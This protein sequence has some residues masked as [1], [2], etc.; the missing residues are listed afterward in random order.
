MLRQW[1]KNAFDF[2]ESLPGHT[3]PAIKGDCAAKNKAELIALAKAGAKRPIQR[4]VLGN[5]LWHYTNKSSSSYDPKFDK[6]IKSLRLDWFKSSA[7]KKK[8]E[9]IVLAKAGTKRP[10]TK[11]SSLGIALSNYTRNNRNTHDPEFDRLIRGLRP[12]WFENTADKNKQE[13]I[14]LAK[15]GAARPSWKTALGR[16]LKS[17]IDKNGGCYDAKFDRLIRSL[18]PDWFRVADSSA[19]KK[20]ELIS[21]AKSGAK[22]P[23]RKTALGMALNSYTSKSSDCYDPEFDKLIK[24]LI[25]DWFKDMESSQKKKE[26]LMSLAKAGAARPNWKTALGQALNSYTSKSNNAYDSDFYKLIK[27]LRP[28]WF[29][30]GST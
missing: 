11:T 22:R 17:Y 30:N 1:Q 25:P 13:M 2:L 29:K 3:W 15:S 20:Q 14:T 19:K 7:Q 26:E 4:T 24:S 12:D 27:S 28:D 23:I 16:A 18:R 9:L 6:I 8:E 10:S 5:A 21:L